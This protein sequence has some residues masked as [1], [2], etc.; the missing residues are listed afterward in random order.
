MLQVLVD[1]GVVVSELRT[2]TGL[3]PLHLALQ[4][5]DHDE[6]L[7]AM[8]VGD[9]GLDVDVRD[10]SGDTPCHRATGQ[11]D[12]LRWL[13]DAGADIDAAND[14]NSTPL[15]SACM[16]G[17]KQFILFLLAAGANVH[18]RQTGR[19][20]STPFDLLVER[21]DL[22][23]LS[24][25]MVGH[26]LC[27]YPDDESHSHNS[28]DESHSRRS[29]SEED[30]TWL[31]DCFFAF[32]AAGAD[33]DA[34]NKDGYTAREK[35]PHFINVDDHKKVEA[36]RI[37][38]QEMRI[39]LIRHR[40]LQICIGLQSARLDALLMCEILQQ[41]FARMVIPFHIWWQIA[42][43]VKHFQDDEIESQE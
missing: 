10:F 26:S 42:T 39:D 1:R 21:L 22:A 33:P 36:A 17:D 38:I 4:R 18:T 25:S 35:V 20:R 29:A 28:D 37:R 23:H 9:C 40:A 31:E 13:F 7:L 6:D 3:T 34:P 8:L 14:D 16:F 11:L 5:H 30:T 19:D 32:L 43:T 15:H 2:E 41:S 24:E 12:G 27:P